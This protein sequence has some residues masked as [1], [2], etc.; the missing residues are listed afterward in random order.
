MYVLVTKPDTEMQMF[1]GRSS[2]G[3]GDTNRLT[4]Q[5]R[6]TSFD[7][8]MRKMPVEA[9]NIPVVYSHI[10]SQNVM[11]ACFT[12]YTIH[13]TINGVIAGGEI[14]RTMKIWFAKYRVN[15][16]SKG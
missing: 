2:C 16:P 5:N 10:I 11:L 7:E 3:S 9:L 6:L 15:T 14:Y 12:N 8:R 4:N 1:P 13:D